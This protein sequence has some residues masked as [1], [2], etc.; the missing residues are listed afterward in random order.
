MAVEHLRLEYIQN[1][2]RPLLTEPCSGLTDTAAVSGSI[3][4]IEEI[5]NQVILPSS[6]TEPPRSMQ[7]LYQDSMAMVS[8]LCRSS[9]FIMFTCNPHW[10]KIIHDGLEQERR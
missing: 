7:Q 10:P 5:G 6:Y 1:S 2:H 9:Y 8:M 4:S 3:T